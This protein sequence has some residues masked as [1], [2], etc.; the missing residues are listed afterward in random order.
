MGAIWSYL[1]W[2]KMKPKRLVILDMNKYVTT[3]LCLV[4]YIHQRLLVYRAF[5]PKLQEEFSQVLP[6]LD[7]A[8]LLGQHWTW[9]RHGLDDFI[10]KLMERY[11]VAVRSCRSD[12]LT[13]ANGHRRCGRLRGLKT[14]TSSATMSV[15]PSGCA[16]RH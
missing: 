7:Q 2:K 3:R 8:T 15:L 11:T 1:G 6:Y 12:K 13:V 9:K 10:D 5:A 4:A 16:D 14:S